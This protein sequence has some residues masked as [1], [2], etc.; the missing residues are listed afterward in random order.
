MDF[1]LARSTWLDAGIRDQAVGTARYV[2]PEQAGLVDLA[3]DQRSD[4]YSFGVVLF[5]CLAGKPPFDGAEVGAVL[6]QHLMMGAPD[7]RAWG[8]RVPKAVAEVVNRLLRK[9][10]SERYQSAGAVLTDIE[11]IAAARRAGIADPPVVVGQSDQRAT[12]TEPAFV[13]QAQQLASLVTMLDAIDE[14][15]RLLAVVEG[16]SGSGKS[17]LLEEL[18]RLA[19]ERGTWVLRGQGVDQAA[20]RPFQLLEGVAGGVVDAVAREPSLAARLRER[21]GVF[22][23]PVAAALPRLVPVLSTDRSAAGPGAILPEEYGENR[24]LTALAAFLDALGTA[25]RPALVVLDDCQWAPGVTAKVL[26]TWRRQRAQSDGRV[27]VVASFRSDEVPATSPLRSI[28]PD[29][30]VAPTPLDAGE[31]ADLIGSM[32]GQVPP[33]AVETVRRLSEGSPFMAQ[34]VLRGM[35]ECGALVQ[36][37]SGWGIDPLSHGEVQAS[38]R[39]A[40]FLMRRLDLLSPA[41]VQL[42]EVG[43]TLGKEF[44]LKLAVTLS[45]LS[46]ADA[47]RGVDDALRRRILWV[48]EAA[49][50]ARFL[51]DKLRDAALARLGGAERRTLHLEAAHAI[52]ALSGETDPEGAKTLASAFDLAFHFDAAGRFEEALP[53][54]LRAAEQARAQHGLEIAETNYLIAA[55]GAAHSSVAV[56]A[57]V[58]EGLGDILALRGRY[59]EAEAQLAEA[60]ELTVEPVRRACLEGKLGDVAFRRGDQAKACQLLEGALGQLGHP[61]PR[62]TFALLVGLLWAVLVQALHTLVP[63]LCRRRHRAPTEAET[64][65]MRLHSR[66]TYAYWFRSGMIACGWSHLRGMNLAERFGPSPE[67]AQAYS[68]HAPVLTM[69]PWYSRGITYARRSLAIRTEL[70]DLWGQGQS[71]N[72][73]GVVLYA[74]S[75]YR[76]SLARGQEAVRLLARTGDLWE[77][78]TATWHIAFAHYRLGELGRCADVSAQLHADA[79]EIGDQTSAGIALSSWSRATNGRIRKDIVAAE[80]ARRNEDISTATEVRVAEAVR[81]LHQ[82][83]PE[84]AVAMLDLA[85]REIR[86]ARLRQEYT[87]PVG[88]WL[89]TALRAQLETL[90]PGAPSRA[91]LVKRRRRTTI[92]ACRLARSYRNNLPHALRERALAV[93]ADGHTRRARRILERSIKVAHSQEAAYEEAQSRVARGHL[94]LALGWPGAVSDLHAGEAA[95]T[96]LVV[97]SDDDAWSEGVASPATDSHAVEGRQGRRDQLSLARTD[98]FAALLTAGRAIAAAT[99]DGAIRQAINDAVPIVLRAQSC[100]TFAV[101]GTEPVNVTSGWGQAVGDLSAAL[102]AQA[103]STGQVVTASPGLGSQVADSLVLSGVRSALC[104]PISRGGKVTACFYAVHRD[105]A[106]SFGDE[107]QRLAEFIAAVAGATL[108]HVAGSEAR[109]RALAHNSHD[110]TVVTDAVGR[111]KYVS[112]SVTRMLGYSPAEFTSFDAHLVHPDDRQRVVDAFRLSRFSPATHPTVE[113]RIQHG[114]GSWRWLDMT[115]T[116]LLADSTIRGLV[117]NIRDV[118]DRKEAEVALAQASEQ[119][120]LSF[121]NAPIG[122]AVS[123]IGT[124]SAGSL[125]K[126]NQALADLLGFTREELEGRTMAQLSHPDDQKADAAALALFQANEATT[127]TTE[128]RYRHADGHWIWVHLQASLVAGDDDSKNY[129]ISQMLD[130]TERRAAEEQLTFLALHDPLTGLANRRLLLDRLAVALARAARSGRTVA[131]LYLDLDRFKEVNDTMGHDQGDHLLLQA[132]RRLG[133]LVRESDTLARMGGDEFVLVADDLTGPAEALAIARRVGD[134]LNRPFQLPGDV[135]VSI[136]AS[137]GVALSQGGTDPKTLLRHADVAMYQAKEQGRASHQLYRGDVMGSGSLG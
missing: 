14:G 33:E 111:A 6:H 102:I 4:L 16:E 125:L 108:E 28:R 85:R 78:N 131:V 96:A 122:M 52:Q 44:D 110:L 47:V 94:G 21:L 115:A 66:L 8:V 10:P 32:A 1:G 41:A 101:Q 68:E 17:R 90:P 100:C 84:G 22:T 58:A 89:A 75:R 137:V 40:L 136:T 25:D 69:I 95:V 63:F 124:D 56:R 65:T 82:G 61:V 114:N 60:L 99:S 42:L 103:I 81:L 79:A 104:A 9:D 7:L 27:M 97:G 73:Y 130:I 62:H 120:R 86:R 38:R 93:A 135:S 43:A 106:G 121:E 118:T 59:A 133:E 30:T 19:A 13:G 76:E 55:R 132:S 45:G 36:T 92:A 117:F 64:L 72:F 127:Y 48:D 29:A 107:D 67:L 31:V 134:S 87:A 74:A 83:D 51:H 105:I 2:S 53:Y 116:N 109:F 12:L 18:A 128:K 54:A 26:S 77:M 88:P 3:V 70:G 35:V 119:F 5:E 50:R 49:G 91:A 24:S 112:P 39:A 57:Q 113:F 11:A 46:P 129:V 15:H 23:D 98:R 20:Q 80:L 71:L 126:V 123:S 34:A 37:P